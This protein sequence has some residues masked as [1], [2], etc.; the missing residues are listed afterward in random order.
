MTEATTLL[1]RADLSAKMLGDLDI[2]ANHELSIFL[3]PTAL[4]QSEFSSES[5]S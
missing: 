5:M 1:T 3:T 4:I 2:I